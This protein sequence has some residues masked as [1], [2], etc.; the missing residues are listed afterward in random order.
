MPLN[1]VEPIFDSADLDVLQQ[2]YEEACRDIGVDPHPADKLLHKE[3][4]E[5]LASFIF[6]MAAAGLRDP[7]ILKARAL[8]TI[9]LKPRMLRTVRSRTTASG[10]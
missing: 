8:R 9:R 4:R 6:K 7:R 2:A 3:T 5:A 10:G 1:T